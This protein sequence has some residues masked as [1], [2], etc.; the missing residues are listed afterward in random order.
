[1][2][3]LHERDTNLAQAEAKLAMAVSEVSREHGL[4]TAEVCLALSVVLSRWAKYE[5]RDERLT[6]DE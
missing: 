3:Q 6:T 1:M 5:V 2:P 4:T